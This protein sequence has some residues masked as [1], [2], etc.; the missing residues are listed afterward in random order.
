MHVL[1]PAAAA[2]GEALTVHHLVRIWFAFDAGQTACIACCNTDVS[3]ATQVYSS[4]RG[5]WLVFMRSAMQ[6]GAGDGWQSCAILQRDIDTVK[7]YRPSCR[8]GMRG[9]VSCGY[10]AC[11][12]IAVCDGS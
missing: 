12:T 10:C 9:S 1:L 5:A 4:M 2:A 3:N 7:D 8:A 11:A 6:S